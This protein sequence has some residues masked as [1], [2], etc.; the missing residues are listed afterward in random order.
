[1]SKWIDFSVAE[2]KAMIQRV[3]N[4]RNIDE[5]QATHSPHDSAFL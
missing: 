5:G 2:R 1:M 4:S 3:V